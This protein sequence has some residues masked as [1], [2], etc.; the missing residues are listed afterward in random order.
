VL[1]AEKKLA[2]N[3]KKYPAQLCEASADHCHVGCCF[4]VIV[5]AL[6]L[7]NSVFG[8]NSFSVSGFLW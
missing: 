4:L 1:A 5:D 8:F 7:P 3:N 6:V 2:L